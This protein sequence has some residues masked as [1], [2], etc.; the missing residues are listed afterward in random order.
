MQLDI[1]VLKCTA[2]EAKIIQNEQ[3]NL[4][5]EKEQVIE[6]LYKMYMYQWM[7]YNALF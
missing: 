6:R 5:D 7:N 2:F 1:N 4:Y 3:Q